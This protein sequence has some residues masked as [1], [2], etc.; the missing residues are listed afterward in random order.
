[1]YELDAHYWDE[2]TKA[3]A[4]RQALDD[5]HNDDSKAG[6]ELRTVLSAELLAYETH[7]LRQVHEAAAAFGHRIA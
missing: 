1:M 6:R 3:E 2:V 5:A 4:I 7:L